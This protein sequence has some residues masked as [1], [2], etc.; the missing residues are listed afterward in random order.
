M[1]S[2]QMRL[3]VTETV[4]RTEPVYWLSFKWFRQ[5]NRKYEIGDPVIITHYAFTDVSRLGVITRLPNRKEGRLYYE[6]ATKCH[7]EGMW[8]K[9]WDFYPALQDD[10]NLEEASSTLRKR[11]KISEKLKYTPSDL[12]PKLFDDFKYELGENFNEEHGI[13]DGFKVYII[14]DG[15]IPHVSIA[16]KGKEYAEMTMVRLDKAKYWHKRHSRKL[17][18]E[19]K[20]LLQKFFEFRFKEHYEPLFENEEFDPNRTCWEQA[21]MAF[22]MDPKKLKMPDY[23]K[24]K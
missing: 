15:L 4:R 14:Y 21:C 13:T 6:V 9:K 7:P 5:Y 19:E 22:G 10:Q 11:D 8:M 17:N 20:Q 18:N 16:F 2:R 24:L 3:E 23:T 12:D 1:I